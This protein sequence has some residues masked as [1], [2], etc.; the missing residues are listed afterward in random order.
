MNASTV[1]CFFCVC[2]N[3]GTKNIDDSQLICCTL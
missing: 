2:D 3:D 1:G